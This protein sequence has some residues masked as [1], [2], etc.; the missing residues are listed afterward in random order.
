MDSDLWNPRPANN[1]HGKPFDQRCLNVQFT[2]EVIETFE[3]A[4]GGPRLSAAVNRNNLS[5]V[6]QTEVA[7]EIDFEAHH[8]IRRRRADAFWV[9]RHIPEETPD[10]GLPNE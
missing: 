10:S 2:L 3:E 1:G 9:A 7:H 5:S 6:R 4:W 8:G